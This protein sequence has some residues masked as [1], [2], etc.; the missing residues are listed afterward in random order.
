MLLTI[1]QEVSHVTFEH[2]ILFFSSMMLLWYFTKLCYN[3]SGGKSCHM[4]MCILNFFFWYHC[5]TLLN[6]VTHN[7]S[8]SKLRH[9]WMW[10]FTFSFMIPLWYFTKLCYSQSFRK[11]VISQ[12]V[13]LLFS[14][15]IPLWY[16]TKLCYS[17]SFRMQ[18]I[19]Q[20]VILFFFFYDTIVILY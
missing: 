5:N 1:F 9:M 12:C 13:I 17:Q 15:I 14:F 6:C 19:S 2:A 20:C 4:W 16:F 3:F 18:V 8:G 11:Q 10:T 7:H